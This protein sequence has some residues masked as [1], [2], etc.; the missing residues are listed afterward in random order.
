M[1]PKAARLRDPP[2]GCFWQLPILSVTNCG[3]DSINMNT[4][5]NTMIELKKLQFHIP[6]PEKKSKCHSLHIG[7]VSQHCPGMKVHGHVADKVTEAV[8]LGDT[9]ST[10]GKNTS[11]I[12]NRVNKG[13]GIVT[14][15]MDML[16]NVSFGSKYFEIA[17]T[18]REAHLI[19]GMLTNFE[20]WYG[21]RENEITALEEVD[22]LLLRRIL[23]V[24][25]STCL[26]SLYLELGNIP[27][28]ILLKARRINELHHLASLDQNSMLY[29]VFITQWK[30]PA[31]DDWTLKVKENLKELNIVLRYK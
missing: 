30:Y 21:L 24:P 9:I 31:K 5:V 14:K 28:H 18:L 23:E 7:K 29:K 27:I 19:N 8:Y 1:R 3:F 12:S 15:V 16:K 10:D 17:I 25:D 6:E 26:E 4:T 13:L 2:S 20:I 22:R 11:N